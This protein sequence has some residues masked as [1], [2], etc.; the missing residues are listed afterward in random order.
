MRLKNIEI[1]FKVKIKLILTFKIVDIKL[2]NFY[3]GLKVDGN[4]EK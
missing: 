4:C 2:I 3:L 1:I